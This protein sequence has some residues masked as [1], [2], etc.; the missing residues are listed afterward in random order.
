MKV[1]IWTI[2]QEDSLSTPSSTLD[3]QTNQISAF[4]S[5]HTHLQPPK[6]SPIPHFFSQNHIFSFSK[7]LNNI[8]IFSLPRMLPLFIHIQTP[9]ETI[10][11]RLTGLTV[12]INSPHRNHRNRLAGFRQ[13][14]FT[15]EQQHTFTHLKFG[16]AR[17]GSGAFGQQDAF[18]SVI[19]SLP[20]NQISQGDL[21]T[22]TPIWPQLSQFMAELLHF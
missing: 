19:L 6:K 18:I 21:S 16:S 15:M 13:R 9:S 11:Y 22:Q 10:M 20:R 3:S 4:R 17:F 12:G 7:Q 5:S 2:A 8:P 1:D 14:K